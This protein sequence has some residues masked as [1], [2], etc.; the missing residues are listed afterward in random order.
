MIGHVNGCDDVPT[1]GQGGLPGLLGGGIGG[2]GVMLAGQGGSLV[3]LLLMELVPLAHGVS[4]SVMLGVVIVVE[5]IVLVSHLSLWAV[6]VGHGLRVA[7]LGLLDLGCHERLV[8]K[9]SFFCLLV[10]NRLLGLRQGTE[11]G[12]LICC[13]HVHGVGNNS[14]LG[15]LES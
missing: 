11:R 10:F 14:Q 3:V 6:L 13:V 9:F 2:T 5:Q 8:L 7:K 15:L 12:I 4:I 1:L